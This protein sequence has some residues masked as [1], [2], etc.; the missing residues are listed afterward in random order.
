[1]SEDK[2]IYLSVVIPAYNEAERIPKTLVAIDAYLSRVSYPYEILVVNDGSKDNTAEVVEKMAKD[3]K[4]L[5]LIDNKENKGKGGVTR[6]GMLAAH[7]AYRLFTDADNS[8]SVDH[9]EKMMPL[10]EDG[11]DVVIGSRAVKGA[12]L[13][14]PEP[15]Y[16][17]ILGK[18]GN[19]VIQLVNVPGIW[20]TQCGFKAFTAVAA[21]KV[22]SLSRVFGWGFDIEIL[23][24]ARIFGYK[25]REI[26][27]HWVN[28]AASHVTLAAYLKVFVE[29]VKIRWWIW[30]NKYGI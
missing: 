18:A 14:P 25:I 5:I 17:Q 3:I 30:T 21:E 8:T 1:M 19:L 9:F 10:F 13:D 23:A 7:G 16:K 26:P 29:N 27:V 4:G 15:F 20:D 12:R 6:Q 22:F 24:L 11:C 28:D 2:A